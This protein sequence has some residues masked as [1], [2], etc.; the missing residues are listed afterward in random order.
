[1]MVKLNENMTKGKAIILAAFTAWPF[2][3]PAIGLLFEATGL[4]SS[5]A[6]EP[7]AA[8]VVFYALLCFTP[9]EMLTLL[10]FYLGYLLTR[11]RL[12]LD[13]KLV[14]AAVLV[15]GHVFTMPVFWYLHIWKPR[16]FAPMQAS[17]RFS[18]LV[19]SPLLLM[20]LLPLMVLFPMTLIQIAASSPGLGSVTSANTAHYWAW[21]VGPVLGAAGI[22]VVGRSCYDWLLRAS[23]RHVAWIFLWG[24][25]TVMSFPVIWYATLVLRSMLPSDGPPNTLK[26]LT[27]LAVVLAL[28]AQPFVLGWLFAVSRILR[29]FESIETGARV[30]PPL[31]G[32]G[33]CALLLSVI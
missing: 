28:V 22:F 2:V 10:I 17:S 15:I 19:F 8:F 32:M 29:R 25:F 5:A 21:V 13:W 31:G 3:V 18:L 30:L 27:G 23:S 33:N 16:Y 26:D 1:M 4:I 6:A 24:V 20:L 7:P 12:S 14:W 9:I 11:P